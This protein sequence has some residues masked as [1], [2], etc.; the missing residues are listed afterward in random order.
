[1]QSE[2]GDRLKRRRRRR[3]RG[4]RKTVLKRALI[5]FFCSV[6]V[7]IAAL[8]AVFLWQMR[9][10]AASS[11]VG[12]CFQDGAL[13]LTWNPSFEP[14]ACRLY[15][16]DER[17]EKYVSC[18]EYRGETIL[19]DN[20][21]AGRKI[22]LRLRAV[23]YF[24]LFGRRM[25]VLGFSR[26]LTV[27]PTESNR[28]KLNLSANPTDRMVSISW[29]ADQ[30]SA[31][32]AYLFDQYGK[33]HLYAT[34]RGGSM[35]LDFADEFPLPD[36]DN[37]VRV[38]VRAVYHEKDYTVYS[39]MSDIAAIERADLLENQLSL[40]WEQIGERQ[41][42]LNWQE[43]RGEWYEIQQWSSKDNGWIRKGVFNWADPMRYTTEYLPSYRQ[44]RFRVISY[45][46]EAHNSDEAQTAQR[47]IE[48][49]EA[50]PSE[51]TFHTEMSTRYCTV[52]PIVPLKI[53]DSPQA[54]N[55]LGE[56][57]AGQALCVLEEE[58]DSFQILYKGCLGYIDSRFCMINLPEYIGDLCE[59]NIANSIQ[60]IFTVHG[61]GIPEITDSVVK[62]YENVCIGRGGYLVPYLYPCTRKLC[63][64]ASS[65]A[66]D[67][68]CFRIYDAFRPNEA[69]RY[70]YDTVASLIDAPILEEGT[71]I[72][73][74]EEGADIPLPEEGISLP[75]AGETADASLMG[76]G[77][78]APLTGENGEQPEDAQE[79]APYL[80]LRKAMTGGRYNLS[81]FLA[82]SVSAHNKG[83]A[84]DLTLVDLH[85]GKELPMQ[86]DM[87]DLSWHSS[88]SQNNNNARLLA[89]YMKGAGYNDL[90]SEWW[91][92]QDDETKEKIGLNTYLKNGVSLEGWKKDPIGWKY[93]LK[94]GSFYENTAVA[95]DGEERAF[96]ADGYCAG[97]GAE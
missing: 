85:T 80:T 55:A 6:L 35:L 2:R 66:K 1:M 46:D 74:L 12:V 67:G 54:G 50:E 58:G 65:A 97:V 27:I 25:S 68:Y 29:D 16:Y 51:V 42:V 61:Y 24:S 44:M 72:P 43:C 39:P 53:M 40:E 94:D 91:H 87:H 64:A 76:E 4:Y 32:E 28:P 78:D 13:S 11:D 70:L 37:P 17:A 69:T 95:I 5:G 83:I 41:Y 19:I 31:Y 45:N 62:G 49:F 93:Q 90:F 86:S 48:I 75:A 52:W 34:I 89:R 21:T 79:Q 84:L 15:Q 96:D 10:A 60:S 57:P 81:S 3:R 18:G 47:D 73:V 30:R 20:V 88:L 23:H 82:A 59:Y 77:M 63:L 9:S 14:D 71:D 92:F 8:A 33:R 26:E 56:V 38:A 36:R 22:A 7:G